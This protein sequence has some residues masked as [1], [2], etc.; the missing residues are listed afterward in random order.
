M[1][2]EPGVCPGPR[3]VRPC[4]DGGRGALEM[5]SVLRI[6]S[7]LDTHLLPTHPNTDTVMVNWYTIDTLLSA[8]SQ[9]LCVLFI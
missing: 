2:P 4:I 7:G 5:V 6:V 8:S 9:W 1:L 3:P